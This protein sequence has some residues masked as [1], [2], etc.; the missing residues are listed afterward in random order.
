MREYWEGIFS[1]KLDELIRRF[2][3]KQNPEINIPI[4]QQHNAE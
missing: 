1:N 4:T 3:W 2:K